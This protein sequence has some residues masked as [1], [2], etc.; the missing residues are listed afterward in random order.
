M[1]HTFKG[2]IQNAINPES[3]VNIVVKSLEKEK[4]ILA[5][6]G[7]SYDFDKKQDKDTLSFTLIPSSGTVEGREVKVELKNGTE[8]VTA[9]PLGWDVAIKSTSAKEPAE[10]A[11]S[12]LR[13][14]E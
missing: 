6:S 11:L 13:K 3:G 1:S 14:M 9:S 7:F 4:I 10:L 5:P 8:K 2:S 12:I